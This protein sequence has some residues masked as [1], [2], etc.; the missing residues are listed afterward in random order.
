MDV[1]ICQKKNHFQIECTL[2]FKGFPAMIKL[3]PSSVDRMPD[4]PVPSGTGGAKEIVQMLFESYAVKAED[5][6]EVIKLEQT[7]PGRTK[8]LLTPITLP[9][10]P[11]NLIRSNTVWDSNPDD[12]VESSESG[13][14]SGW[15]SGSGSGSSSVSSFSSVQS[16]S[17][18]LSDQG[19]SNRNVEDDN[20]ST[21][22]MLI[23]IPRLH[24]SKT[25]RNNQRRG[26]ITHPNQRY[27]LLVCSVVAKTAD[28]NC[29]VIAASH[30]WK[31]VVRAS[32]PAQFKK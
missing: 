24:F 3:I 19:A 25:T 1:L 20:I 23:N 28:G 17:R 7:E 4:S 11:A 13:S 29:H 30:S 14:G 6:D 18:N 32:N 22:V 31:I 12:Q 15:G 8:A 26:G 9:I 10:S 21:I 16:N 27:F 2:R 5:V